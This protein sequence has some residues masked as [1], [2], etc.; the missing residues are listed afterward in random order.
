MIEEAIKD[1]Q[2]WQEENNWDNDLDFNKRYEKWIKDKYGN[3]YKFDKDGLMKHGILCM[4][5]Y[6]ISKKCSSCN[7]KTCL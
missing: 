6:G 1:I 4:F 2:E 3:K 5:G 7:N